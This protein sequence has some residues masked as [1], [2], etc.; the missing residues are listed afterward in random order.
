[1]EQLTAYELRLTHGALKGDQAGPDLPVDVLPLDLLLVV[2][3]LNE[4]VKVKEAVCYM[5]RY[6]LTMEV[7]ENLRICAH[8]PLVLLSSIQLA[9]IDTATEQGATLVLTVSTLIVADRPTRGAE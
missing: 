5:L 9:A 6:N 3:V 8:H 1:M 7:N 2:H 4:T